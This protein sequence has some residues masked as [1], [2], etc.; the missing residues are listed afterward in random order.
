MHNLMQLFPICTFHSGGMDHNAH[1]DYAW[2]T[3][4]ARARKHCP[5][6]EANGEYYYFSHLFNLYNMPQW[7]FAVRCLF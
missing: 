1:W 6:G 3:L 5:E 7:A 4:L 2:L